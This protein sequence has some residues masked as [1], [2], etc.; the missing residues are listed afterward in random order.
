MARARNIKPGFFKNELLVGLPYEYRLL[1]IG[2][3]TI[4]DRDGRFEDRPV[5]VPPVL[6]SATIWSPI[7]QLKEIGREEAFYRGTDHR[8]PA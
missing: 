6:S 7:P 3:W 5:D 2:L 8:L 1:F 4:A